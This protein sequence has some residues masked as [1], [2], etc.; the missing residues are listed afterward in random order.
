ML[1]ASIDYSLLRTKVC[2]KICLNIICSKSL[3]FNISYYTM[4]Y[5]VF[6][7]LYYS[8]IFPSNF[9]HIANIWYFFNFFL[10]LFL[11]VLSV[12]SVLIFHVSIINPFQCSF[13]R[14]IFD[15]SF[16]L[17]E[18]SEHNNFYIG[19]KSSIKSPSWKTDR[20]DFGDCYFWLSS[21]WLNSYSYPFVEGHLTYCTFGAL[22]FE[23]Y[24]R[25]TR[26]SFA[27]M[28]FLLLNHTTLTGLN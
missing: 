20:L 18:F 10:F 23:F 14:V 11:F 15:L 25:P 6:F 21:S 5:C 4:I 24:C 1:A 17:A 19:C 13:F 8:F 2:F 7:L 3:E 9:L 27:Q 12:Y 28:R 16:F 22:D 26:D